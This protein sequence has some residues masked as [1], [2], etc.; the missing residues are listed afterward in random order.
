[1]PPT[2]PSDHKKNIIILLIIAVLAAFGFWY[3]KSRL[4]SPVSQPIV[5]GSPVSTPLPEP[6]ELHFIQG[7]IVQVVGKTLMVKVSKLVG[8][9]FASSRIVTEEYK[10]TV[11]DKTEL[12]KMVSSSETSAQKAVKATLKDFK[13]GYMVA[14]YADRNL[15]QF[16]EFTAVK[17]ELL[18]TAVMQKQ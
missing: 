18:G 10:V 8:S 12:V 17:V 11:D 9:S 15:V 3:Y 6:K 1:M 16:K 14:A 7:E 2:P 4:S 5:S 13:K